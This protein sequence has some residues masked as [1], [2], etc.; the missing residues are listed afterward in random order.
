MALDSFHDL[1]PISAPL[2]FMV[3]FAPKVWNVASRANAA[4]LPKAVRVLAV[5]SS[6]CLGEDT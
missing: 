5:V 1:G 4:L 2:C 6:P 3:V